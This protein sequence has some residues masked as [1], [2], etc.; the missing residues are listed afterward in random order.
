[1]VSTEEMNY[2][3]ATRLTN[4]VSGDVGTRTNLSGFP[5]YQDLDADFVL[6]LT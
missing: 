3:A 6:L 4:A 2:L 1:M 5:T